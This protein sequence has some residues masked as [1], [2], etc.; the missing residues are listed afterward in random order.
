MWPARNLKFLVRHLKKLLLLFCSQ[1]NSFLYSSGLIDVCVIVMYNNR[2]YELKA[3]CVRFGQINLHLSIWLP[4]LVAVITSFR[5]YPTFHRQSLARHTDQHIYIY[6]PTLAHGKSVD[7]TTP[8]SWRPQQEQQ[9]A[10][11]PRTHPLLVQGFSS[12]RCCAYCFFWLPTMLR[13]Y[14]Q[15]RWVMHRTDFLKWPHA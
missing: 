6:I 12:Y 14:Y 5:S 8:K 3:I 2:R 13:G 9:H 11:A 4:H 1:G 10:R 7:L 15:R